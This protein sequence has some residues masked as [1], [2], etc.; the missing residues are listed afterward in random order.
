MT[1]IK[2]EITSFVDDHQPGYVECSFVDVDGKQHTFV[3]KVPVVSSENLLPT[4][5]YPRSGAID[6]EVQDRWTSKRGVALARVSTDK[7]WGIES[8]EGLSDF[9]VAA[10]QLWP[11]AE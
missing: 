3:E 1:S 4:S 8:S 6:C 9:V 10:S 11:I 7:P 5:A 2:I